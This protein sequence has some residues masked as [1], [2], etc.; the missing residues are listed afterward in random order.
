MGPQLPPQ[1]VHPVRQERDSVAVRFDVSGL[2]SVNGLGSELQLLS[3]LSGLGSE[4]Q[5]LSADW[6]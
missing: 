2:V 1:R 4:L 3:G 5:L 6:S